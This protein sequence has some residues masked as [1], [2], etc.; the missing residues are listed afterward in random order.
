[1]KPQAMEPSHITCFFKHPEEIPPETLDQISKLIKEGSG[2]GTSW[3]RENLQNAFLIGYAQ[4]EGMVVGTSTH[5]YPKEAYR[6][7]IEAA[8]GLDLSSHLERGYTAVKAEYRGSGIGGRLIRGLIE[9][10]AGKNIYVTIRMDNVPPLKMTYKE[11]MVLA[12]T[13]INERTGHELGVF[14]NQSP[15]PS[16]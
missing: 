12:G 2:V 1:L 3:V 11:G 14:T 8:T 7:K 15:P 16:R 4:H 13:F 5:K 10:S 9:R 6:K